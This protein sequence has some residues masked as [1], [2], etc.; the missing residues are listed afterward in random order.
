MQSVFYGALLLAL[1]TVSGRAKA[2]APFCVDNGYN[3]QCFYFDAGSCQRAAASTNA[4]C[5][6]NPGSARGTTAPIAVHTMIQQQ[7]DFAKTAREGYAAGQEARLREEQIKLLQ[8]QEQAIAQPV[9]DETSSPTANIPRT[10]V[11]TYECTSDDG[12]K[13]QSNNPYIGCIVVDMK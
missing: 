10:Y 7:P 1:A 11:V 9:P 8:L 5:I 4:V 6:A 12:S 13:W 2:E 3:R